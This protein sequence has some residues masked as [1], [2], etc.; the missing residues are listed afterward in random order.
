MDEVVTKSVVIHPLG[1]SELPLDTF[2]CLL[3]GPEKY[4]LAQQACVDSLGGVLIRPWRVV[5]QRRR[6]CFIIDIIVVSCD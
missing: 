1:E 4:Y 5:L 3:P 2:A 6:P